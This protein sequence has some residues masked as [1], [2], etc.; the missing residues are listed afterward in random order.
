MIKARGFTDFRELP[1]RT[2]EL[3]LVR[4]FLYLNLK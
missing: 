2:E 3:L 4:M 1:D